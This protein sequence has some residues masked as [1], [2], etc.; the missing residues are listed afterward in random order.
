MQSKRNLKADESLR[1]DVGLIKYGQR[2]GG[3]NSRKIINALAKDEDSTIRMKTSMVYL[4][5]VE[6][7]DIFT[8]YRGYNY[9][10]L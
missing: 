4:P 2:G 5:P 9:N 3:G 8:C 6:V 10:K 7:S 1:I